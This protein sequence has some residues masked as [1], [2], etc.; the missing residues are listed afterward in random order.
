ML[1]GGLGWI[2]KP[3]RALEGKG[4]KRGKKKQKKGPNELEAC[5]PIS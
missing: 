1:Q 4:K 2:Y 5:Q 3:G